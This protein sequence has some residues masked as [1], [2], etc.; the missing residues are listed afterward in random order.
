[1]KEVIVA[2]KALD[3][4][5]MKKEGLKGVPIDTKLQFQFY[6]ANFN[7][8]IVTTKVINIGAN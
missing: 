4:S 6:R 2:G 7:G 1:M 5:L 8:I 3:L